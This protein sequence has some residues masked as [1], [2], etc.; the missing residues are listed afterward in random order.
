MR[1]LL[2]LLALLALFAAGRAAAQPGGGI[3]L[4]Y[5]PIE[6]FITDCE[7]EPMP[8]SKVTVYV[9]NASGY[10]HGSPYPLEADENAMVNF[11]PL[12]QCCWYLEVN[13]EPELGGADW[14]IKIRRA[15][16]NCGLPQVVGA[17]ALVDV[18]ASPLCESEPPDGSSFILRYN[19]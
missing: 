7:G 19:P 10:P 4:H 16:N 3:G 2:T 5:Q 14:M 17:W 12:V 8:Y 6:F 9:Y 15:C 1:R 18:P 13:V 11:S